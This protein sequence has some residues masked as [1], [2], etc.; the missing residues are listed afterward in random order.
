MTRYKTLEQKMFNNKKEIKALWSAKFADQAKGLEAYLE[1]MKEDIDFDYIWSDDYVYD[2]D[3]NVTHEVATEILE[4]DFDN[5][6]DQEFY[7]DYAN[8]ISEF[9]NNDLHTILNKFN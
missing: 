2:I 3:Q 8:D 7:S 6:E 5:D 1:D 9:G 4:L